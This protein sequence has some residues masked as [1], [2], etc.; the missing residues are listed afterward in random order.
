[1]KDIWYEIHKGVVTV[2]WEPQWKGH[3]ERRTYG[4]WAHPTEIL[5]CSKASWALL[6]QPHVTS[7]FIKCFPN[8]S[9]AQRS[10]SC[11]MNSFYK[12]GCMLDFWG[13]LKGQE[14]EKRRESDKQMNCVYYHTRWGVAFL[15]QEIEMICQEKKLEAV[16]FYRSGWR[17]CEWG[18]GR[19]HGSMCSSAVCFSW[20]V[21]F[22]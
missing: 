7:F 6:S 20:V 4:L 18:N 10:A 19:S 1:M 3:Q 16:T 14:A 8:L 17:A 21:W 12:K 9:H 13:S 15:L 5:A 22:W 11:H 2:G